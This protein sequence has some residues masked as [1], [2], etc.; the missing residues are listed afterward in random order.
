MTD[1]TKENATREDIL[2]EEQ[3]NKLEKLREKGVDGFGHRFVSTTNTKEIL[4][5]FSDIKEG[6]KLKDK[7]SLAGRLRSIRKHGKI[8]FC[9]LE[10]PLGRIQLC[11]EKS[12]KDFDLFE[13]ISVGDF[14]G[15]HGVVSKTQRGEL[16]IWVDSFELLSK[17]L[18]PLPDEW[19]GLKDV[20]AR[21]RQRYVDMVMN[22]S[23]RETFLKRAEII[24]AMREYLEGRGFVEIDTPILQ[25]I[26]GGALAEPFTTFHNDL[27]RQMY[28]RIAPELYLK[29]AIVGGFDKVYEIGKN[30][31]NEGIDAKHNPEFGAMELYW[32]YADYTDNMKLTEEMI[33]YIAKKVLGKTKIEYQGVVIDLTPPFTRITMHD[34][35]KKYLGLDVQGKSLGQLKEMA[36][37]AGA[38]TPEYAD[39]GIIINELF[40]LVEPKLIQPTF[41]TDFPVEVSPLAKS[42]KHLPSITERFELYINGQEY[43][44]AYTEENDPISQRKKFE[45]QGK[46]RQGGDKETHPMDEDFIRALEY[47]MPPTSGLGVGL[48]R[49]IMLLTNSASIRDVIMFPVL[50]E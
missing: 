26:Y 34:A 31:R 8:I 48:D 50:K 4:D 32:A 38:K 14:L 33:A 37:K 39:E 43:A 44:N 35:I 49:L 9:H 3:L 15:V 25:P 18:R 19:F 12:V 47:G 10:D 5:K 40:G 23:V 16:T 30:F 29:R 36:H 2:I 20:E 22:P 45:D 13:L 28:L 11:I 21:Y 24:K 41:I 6:E 42:K 27:K 7:I 46:L 17:S 1:K